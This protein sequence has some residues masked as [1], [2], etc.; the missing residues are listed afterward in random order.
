[1]SLNS[2]RRRKASR[3]L[4]RKSPA[5]SVS[6][7]HPAGPPVRRWGLTQMEKVKKVDR[8]KWLNMDSQIW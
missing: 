8:D 4:S 1:M 6:Q 2:S 7:E 5:G 3:T